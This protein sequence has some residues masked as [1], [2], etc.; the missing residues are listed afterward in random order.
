LEKI[1]KL[2]LNIVERPGDRVTDEEARNSRLIAA[3][4]TELSLSP[5]LRFS[6]CDVP[7]SSTSTTTTTAVDDKK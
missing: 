6:E 5:R 7:V 3:W 2:E 4:N 1:T